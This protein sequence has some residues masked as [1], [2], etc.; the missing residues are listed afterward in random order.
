MRINVM[1]IKMRNLLCEHDRTSDNV[2]KRNRD[3]NVQELLDT[4]QNTRVF[5]TFKL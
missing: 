1:Y 5:I 3:K 4:K 2:N